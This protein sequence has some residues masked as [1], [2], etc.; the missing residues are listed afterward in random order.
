MTPGSSELVQDFYRARF[1]ADLEQALARLNGKSID[2]LNYEEVRQKLRA[3]ATSLRVLKDIPISSIV[4]S[5]G[6]HTDFNRGFLPRQ[7]IDAERWARLK[8]AALDLEGLPPIEVYQIGEAYFVLDGNHRVSVARDLGATHIEAYVTEV[9]ARVS[10]EADADI[11][12]IVRKAAYVEFIERTE[13]D[14]LHPEADLLASSPDAYDLLERH[15]DLH[16]YVMSVEQKRGIP[17]REAVADWYDAVYLPVAQ[18]IREQGALEEF[19]GQSEADLYLAVS[20]YRALTEEVLDWEFEEDAPSA[21]LPARPQEVVRRLTDR[22]LRREREAARSTGGGASHALLPG[23][24]RRDAIVNRAQA[25][26]SENFRLFTSL[27][28]PVNGE[29]RSWGALDQALLVARRERGR[30]LG[31]FVVG[32]EAG[33]ESEPAKRVETEFQRRCEEAGVPGRLAIAVG[34]VSRTICDR[35]QWVDMTVVS[36]AHPPP[37]NTLARFSSGFRALLLG[38]RSPL[39]AVPARGVRAMERAMLAYNGSEQA[40]EALFV[41]AYLAQRQNMALSVVSVGQGDEVDKNLA[42]AQ[43]YL[44]GHGVKAT[45]QARPGPPAETVIEA[46][47]AF[48]AHV[49]LMGGYSRRGVSEIMRGSTVDEVLRTAGRP[50]LICP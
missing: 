10:L 43:A 15:I 41:A 25:L 30:L 13:L 48:N 14:R 36:L 24:W 38:C 3:V 32:D 8:A 21:Q 44:A 47:G 42:N 31:L 34:E 29:E 7:E 19:P 28:V 23:E 26:A 20:G 37:S 33:R 9:A 16:R 2:L 40:D 5:V 22:V 45:Y 18:V 46:A 6:R 35:S 4:G 27:M 39:L 11:S 12:E 49:I 1:R 50:V 17:Y